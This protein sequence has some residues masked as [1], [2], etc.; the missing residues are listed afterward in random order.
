MTDSTRIPVATARPYDVVV[1]RG[2]LGELPGMLGPEAQRAAIIHPAALRTS[3]EAV[4]EDLLAAG[5]AAILIE[6]P[7]AEDAKTAQ[8]AAFCWGV[9]GQAGFTRSDVIVSVGGGATS[10]GAEVGVACS[11][12]A[13]VCASI[14]GAA[15]GA[16]S[17][18]QAILPA[19]PD[20]ATNTATNKYCFMLVL[21][22]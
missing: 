2:L 22:A 14:T 11:A 15:K 8:V 9:L 20:T 1:G 13:A 4:R 7:D 17:S 6:T 12:G 3:A 5:Y 16:G 19:N 18:A 10:T 21:L